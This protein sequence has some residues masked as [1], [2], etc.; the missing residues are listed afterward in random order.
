MRLADEPFHTW[1]W[2]EVEAAQAACRAA[3]AQATVRAADDTRR[4]YRAMILDGLVS[5]RP[6]PRVRYRMRPRR[7]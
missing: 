3:Q 5:I 4:G 6:A 2:R 7:R 1:F